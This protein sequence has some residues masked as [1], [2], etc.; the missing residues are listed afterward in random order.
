MAQTLDVTGGR[1]IYDEFGDGPQTIVFVHG[2]GG[3][4][5]SWWQQIPVFRDRFRCVTYEVRGWGQSRDD[6]GE[7][8]R[9]FA[10]DLGELMDALEV[11]EAVLVGQ[12]MGGVLDPAVCGAQSGAGQRVA[13]GRHLPRDRRA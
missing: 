7:G 10:R 3:N 1:L 4:H 6:S 8:R 12:S 5:L 13:D 11:P 2:A 9:A